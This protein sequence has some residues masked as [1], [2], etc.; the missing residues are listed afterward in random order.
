LVLV[1]A[2]QRQTDV[3]PL[4]DD[5][6][7]VWFSLTWFN[8]IEPAVGSRM[9]GLTSSKLGNSYFYFRKFHKP[10]HFAITLAPLQ[11]EEI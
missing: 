5:D 4:L 7:G 10:A 9:V 11:W 3:S 2:F 1:N 6:M 8:I